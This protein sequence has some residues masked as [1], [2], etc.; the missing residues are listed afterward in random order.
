[1]RV[2]NGE[3]TLD[4]VYKYYT[5]ETRKKTGELVV[6]NPLPIKE[7]KE[8]LYTYLNSFKE[9]LLDGK[10]LSLGAYLGDV[11]VSKKPINLDSLK[12]DYGTYNKEGI[13]TFHL[14]EH[15]G[16][17]RF[18]VLWK[19]SKCLVAGKRPYCFQ[20]ARGLKRELAQRL[21]VPN[22]HTNYTQGT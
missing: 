16:G 1:M 4:E 17:F 20:A 13:K 9:A 19:K 15:T 18:R 14:N 2:N 6:K 12:F 21:S 8:V 5:Q 10:V 7:F 3:H 11:M 22:A